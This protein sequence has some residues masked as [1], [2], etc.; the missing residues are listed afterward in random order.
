MARMFWASAA[1]FILGVALAHDVVLTPSLVTFFL[2]LAVTLAVV[3]A[4]EPALSLFL[5]CIVVGVWHGDVA[6]PRDPALDA[7]LGEDISITGTVVAEPDE[8]ERSTRLTVELE[9][10]ARVLVIAP[11]H[12]SI[13]YGDRIEARGGLGLPQRFETGEGRVFDY[14]SYL[15]LSGIGY[16]LSFAAV[17]RIGEGDG[18]WFVARAIALKRWYVDGLE[19]A[20]GEPHAGL[21]TGITAGEKRGL[22]EE[23]SETFRV[24]GLTHIIVLSGYNIMIVI[25][26]FERVLARAGTCVRFGASAFVAVFFVLM[27]GFASAS[28][29]AAAM[30]LIALLARAT[31]RSYIALRALA[32]VALVM[33]L[34]N[35]RLL[36]A[37]PGFQL[38]I[39]ATWGLIMLAPLVESRISFITDSFGLRGI[40]ASTI[41]TQLAVLPL[42]LYQ[43]GMLSVMSLP[44]NVLTLPFVPLAMLA[45]FVAGVAGAIAGPLA[46][47]FGG[48]AYAL[49]S[50]IIACAELFAV[51][52]F[53]HVTVP[54]F[55]LPILF[56]VYALLIAAVHRSVTRSRPS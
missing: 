43:S 45:S 49:L 54:P 26:F 44:V 29:R 12:S 19:R 6:I 9:S 17:E 50:F 34:I 39:I 3:A 33:I 42:I 16:T 11:N 37:D 30:A 7:A 32:L 56:G 28:V 48:P 4:R 31:G 35:P 25:A 24:V 52:P 14:P 36:T 10:G 47:V 55:P 41:G 8:R 40:V 51:A 13:A 18:S 22:G 27:T 2:L 46:A 20:L 15:A 21:A 5:I 1:G 53:S 38:S 23:L